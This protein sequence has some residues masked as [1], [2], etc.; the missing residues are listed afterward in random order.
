MISR[1]GGGSRI[2]TP[3]RVSAAR[4]K[5]GNAMDGPRGKSSGADSLPIGAFSPS[6]IRQS[7]FPA[8]IDD[9]QGNCM[10]L[11]TSEFIVTGCAWSYRASRGLTDSRIPEMHRNGVETVSLTCRACNSIW[12]AKKGEDYGQ[13]RPAIS[14][15]HVT[16]P[17]CETEGQIALDSM[18]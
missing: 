18:W 2:A 15:I 3:P 16:C 8:R 1:D 9:D 6:R 10:R 4:S 17:N 5:D 13:F 7:V 12:V 14:A 11:E